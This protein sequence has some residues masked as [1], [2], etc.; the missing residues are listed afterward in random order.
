[1]DLLCE[2]LA[3]VDFP[4]TV[5]TF[6]NG[7]LPPVPSMVQVRP[8]GLLADEMSLAL[9]YSAADAFLCPSREDN[10][11]NTVAEAMA[12]GT[13]CVAFNVNGLPDMIDHEADGW[14]ASPFDAEDFLRGLRFIAG[15]PAPQ[16]LREAAR[17][18]ALAEYG[19]ERMSARYGALYDELTAKSR[20]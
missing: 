9:A 19:L 2:A 15:H 6:G 3:R 4:C 12:C 1:M 11:P 18:K 7:A 13:P 8:L 20:T 14:L 16:G 5:L 10:L 17:A